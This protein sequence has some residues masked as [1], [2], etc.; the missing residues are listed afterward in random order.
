MD[1]RIISVRSE[2]RKAFELAFQLFWDNCP[3]KKV[4]HFRHDATFGMILYWHETSGTQKLPYDMDLTAACDMA[5]GWLTSQP[6]DAYGDALDHDG[7]NGKGFHMFNEAWGHVDGSSY[8][9]L[10]VKPIWAWYG[11]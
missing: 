2:G 7:S 11:K 8:A 4:S 3:G 10:A 9:V 5:W 1:N 6:K